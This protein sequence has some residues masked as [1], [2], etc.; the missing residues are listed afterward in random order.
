MN[1]MNTT[2]SH[3]AVIPLLPT[4]PTPTEYRFL[5]EGEV[6]RDGDEYFHVDGGWKPSLCVGDAVLS[7]GVSYYRRPTEK[8]DHMTGFIAQ[9]YGDAETPAVSRTPIT[10]AHMKTLPYAWDY[11]DYETEKLLKQME[12]EIAELRKRVAKLETKLLATEI[13]IAGYDYYMRKLAGHSPLP[14]DKA[15]WPALMYQRYADMLAEF[16]DFKDAMS[17]YM[18]DSW[19]HEAVTI[20]EIN[21]QH[22]N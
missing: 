2:T 8:V 15:E 1:T 17:S 20:Y 18:G 9:S 5:N 19:V 22:P 14:E 12:L 11:F 16:T 6:I 7:G 13:R 4:E 10:D 3:G 21:N